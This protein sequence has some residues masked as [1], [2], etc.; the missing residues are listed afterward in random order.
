MAELKQ[1]ERFAPTSVRFHT[2]VTFGTEVLSHVDA[3]PTGK[4]KEAELEL[5]QYGVLIRWKNGKSLIVPYANIGCVG[6]ED[7]RKQ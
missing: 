7:S 4:H 1:Q 2:A 6:V 5:T 3:T